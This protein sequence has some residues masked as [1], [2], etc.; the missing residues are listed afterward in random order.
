MSAV[1]RR[2]TACGACR[3]TRRATAPPMTKA[4]LVVIAAGITRRST[5]GAP[6]VHQLGPHLSGVFLDAAVRRGLRIAPS[7]AVEVRG[8]GGHAS[9]VLADGSALEGD[10]VVSAAGDLPNT[11]WL[12]D[13][14]LLSDGAL[15]VDTRG[16]LRPDIVAAGDVAA[17]PTPRGIRRIPLWTSAIEQSRVAATALLRG[18]EAPELDLRP[19]FWTEQSGLTLGA[20]GFLPLAGAPEVLDGDPLDGSALLRWAHEILSTVRTRCARQG[21]CGD[22]PEMIPSDCN[23]RRRACSCASI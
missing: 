6:M 20:S 21:F 17:L 23:S 18:D 13:S 5:A 11:E 14:G 3:A 7:C 16:R 4:V 9:V 12:A 19:C 10:L 15:R 22:C 2:S 8:T 1:R